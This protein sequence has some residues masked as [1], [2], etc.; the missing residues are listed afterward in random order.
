L[1]TNRNFFSRDTIGNNVYYEP[2]NSAVLADDGLVYANGRMVANYD[3]ILRRY[4]LADWQFSEYWQNLAPSIIAYGARTIALFQQEAGLEPAPTKPGRLAGGVKIRQGIA[5]DAEWPIPQIDEAVDVPD[6]YLEPPPAPTI[7]QPSWPVAG[8]GAGSSPVIEQPNNQGAPATGSP[9]PTSSLETISEEAET[10]AAPVDKIIAVSTSTLE[11]PTSTPSSTATSTA[12]STTT[13]TEPVPATPHQNYLWLF[14]E[15]EGNLAVEANGGLS[16]WSYAD[17]GEGKSGTC[18]KSSWETQKF[19]YAMSPAQLLP[20][21]ELTIAFDVKD[22]SEPG[23]HYETAKIVIQGSSRDLAGIAPNAD[24]IAY[25]FD[26]QRHNFTTALP[27]DGLWHRVVL[28]Y[29]LSDLK[30]FIDGELREVV[31]GDF[32]TTEIAFALRVMGENAPAFIDNLALWDRA[33]M[34]GQ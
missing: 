31:E 3:P 13:S 26:N 11:L 14:D 22:G 7:S 24:K 6:R 17:W 12:T 5:P 33:L 20:A 34:P 10:I 27:P 8:S 1:F 21:G 9:T 28:V 2:F 25:Y 4:Y 15:G 32:R 29:G 18:L 19:A 30:L 23:F 16:I